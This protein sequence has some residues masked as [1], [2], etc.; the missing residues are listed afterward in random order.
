[1]KKTVGL[2]QIDSDNP[3]GDS[4]GESSRVVEGIIWGPPYVLHT[5]MSSME[6][7]ESGDKVEGL[8]ISAGKVTEA[9]K[10]EQLWN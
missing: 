6:E 3:S 4:E 8:L 2:P 7:K 5:G 1:M 9:V 10:H